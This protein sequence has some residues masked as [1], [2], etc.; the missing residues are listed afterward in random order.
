MA[1]S[2][3]TATVVLRGGLRVSVEA[4]LGDWGTFERQYT[5]VL[6]Q[7]VIG[8][9]DDVR[10]ALAR[11]VPRLALFVS[12]DSAHHVT[13]V[14]RIPNDQ[15]PV[16][17]DALAPHRVEGSFTLERVTLYRWDDTSRAWVEVTSPTPEA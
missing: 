4:K 10:T 14:S 17:R 12:K 16:L 7:S 11:V 13:V 9:F 15:L 6:F 1:T 2:S 5:S 3:D 8:A